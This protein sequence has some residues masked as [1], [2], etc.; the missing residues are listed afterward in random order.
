MRI[1]A[2]KRGGVAS[3][4][5]R[6]LTAIAVAYAL[7]IQT[8]FIALGGA[9]LAAYAADNGSP[10]F[11]LCLHGANDGP[12]SPV[13]V[14]GHD[15]DHHC[16]FCFAG[17]Y[18]PLPAAAQSLPRHISIEIGGDWSIAAGWLPPRPF[19][20]AIASPRGPPFGA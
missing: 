16:V 15:G 18:Q 10:G 13:D 6:R 9:Q 19:E 12:L 5:G 11:E 4:L 20:Y 8:L 7:V 3:G 17:A 1:G 2:A 14:P